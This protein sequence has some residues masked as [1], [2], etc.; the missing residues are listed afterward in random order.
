[1]GYNGWNPLRKELEKKYTVIGVD[2]PNQGAAEL[3]PDYENLKDYALFIG[4]FLK[5]INLEPQEIVANGLSFGANV[6][7]ILNTEMKVPFKSVILTG[8]T[9]PSLFSY[10]NLFQEHLLKLLEC[11]GLDLM[12]HEM[13]LRLFSAGFLSKNPNLMNYIR[14]R[15]QESFSHRP[16]AV[17]KLI[18]ASL[19]NRQGQTAPSL[20]FVSPVYFISSLED[21]MVPHVYAKEY[22]ESIQ[23]RGFYEIQ[24]GHLPMAEALDENIRIIKDIMDKVSDNL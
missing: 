21:M 17:K 13:V 4:D 23:C 6:L 3:N 12:S 2:F 7:R 10:M 15:F 24:A 20:P 18:R 19:N 9:P 1:M 14:D 8:C 16:E 5:A 11:G 22:A